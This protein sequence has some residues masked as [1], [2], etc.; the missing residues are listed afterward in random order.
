MDNAKKN[1]GNIK[2]EINNNNI[3]NQ[4]DNYIDYNYYD[5][6][7]L[8]NNDDNNLFISSDEDEDIENKLCL[9]KKKVKYIGRKA[10]IIKS[11]KDNQDNKN[12]LKK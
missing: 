9:K 1:I 3:I 10:K 11:I 8:E 5:Y 6:E 7:N 2:K 4:K 12:K